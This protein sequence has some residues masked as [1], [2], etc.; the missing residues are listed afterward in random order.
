[1]TTGPPGAELQRLT[2]LRGAASSL[3]TVFIFGH[4]KARDLWRCSLSSAFSGSSLLRLSS[5][6]LFVRFFSDFDKNLSF[7]CKKITENCASP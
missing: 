5:G 2:S 3:S 1:M 4:D 7:S 6:K